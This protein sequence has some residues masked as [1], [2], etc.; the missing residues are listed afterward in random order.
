[1]LKKTYR[2]P[3]GKQLASS[4][5]ITSPF[6]TLRY[7][8]NNLTNSRF[9]FIV[10]KRI[11]KRATKRN[12]IRRLL[13]NSIETRIAEI[14]YGKDILFIARKDIVGATSEEIRESVVTMLKKANIIL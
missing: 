14:V 13:A 5:T 8:R 11:D 2:L 1:M 10:S 7:T 6:F 3:L 12:R 9:G 4:Q